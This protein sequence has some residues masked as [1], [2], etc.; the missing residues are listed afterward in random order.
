VD[1][2]QSKVKDFE[3]PDVDVAAA[4][5]SKAI[6]D[7]S[8]NVVSGQVPL[9]EITRQLVASTVESVAISRVRNLGLD[10]KRALGYQIFKE[11]GELD[12]KVVDPEA[13]KRRVEA[14]YGKTHSEGFTLGSERLNS[15]LKNQ[16]EQLC[17][18][19]E[20]LD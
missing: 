20:L 18:S 10:V 19:L 15:Y 2:L 3:K 4:K 17:I 13:V 6:E 7:D 11:D 8:R 14:F 5:L 9:D 1:E 16:S 12:T